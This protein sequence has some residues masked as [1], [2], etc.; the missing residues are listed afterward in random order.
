MK[1]ILTSLFL[2]S[3]LLVMVAGCAHVRNIDR[4]GKEA[5][6]QQVETE[7][8]AK[9]DKKWGTVYDLT[10]EAYRKEVKRDSFINSAN[11]LIKSFDIREIKVLASGKDATVKVYFVIDYMGHDFKLSIN[12]KWLLEN[13]GWYLELIPQSLPG[14][15][16]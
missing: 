5:L 11:A 2:L 4:T 6:R 13:E 9:V 8:N 14:I 16:K 3:F 12:E 1:R 7:W 15:A 10:T